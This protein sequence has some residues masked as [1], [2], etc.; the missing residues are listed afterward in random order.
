MRSR[1]CIGFLCF[2]F[3]ILS[4]N[5]ALKECRA[6]GMEKAHKTRQQITLGID[7]YNSSI[8][9]TPLENSCSCSSSASSCCKGTMNNKPKIS[10]ISLS[11]GDTFRQL[12][13]LSTTMIESSDYTPLNQKNRFFRTFNSLH[14]KEFFLVNCTFLI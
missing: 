9:N 1:I 10:H 6:F 13:V 5:P 2:L 7:W 8:P 4:M 3:L 14:S 12:S 11:S